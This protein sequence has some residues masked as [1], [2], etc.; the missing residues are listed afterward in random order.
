[1]TSYRL[2]IRNY[3]LFFNITDTL[4]MK[5]KIFYTNN[6]KTNHEMCSWI[7]RTYQ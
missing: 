1:M 4:Q 5:Y 3:S 7:V 2:E 6:K